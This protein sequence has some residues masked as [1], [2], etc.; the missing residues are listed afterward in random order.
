MKTEIRTGVVRRMQHAREA[1]RLQRM[2]RRRRRLSQ[3]YLEHNL[4][5]EADDARREMI[6]CLRLACGQWR[7]VLGTVR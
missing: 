3:F 2:A 5:D 1:F 6:G 7:L 4:F